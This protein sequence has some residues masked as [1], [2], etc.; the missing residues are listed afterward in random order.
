MSVEY[1]KNLVGKPIVKFDCPKCH[2][3]LSAMLAE[4]GTHDTCPECGQAFRVPGTLQL[5]K[6]QE[7][8]KL[9][10]EAKALAKQQR[11]R[12]SEKIEKRTEE[13]QESRADLAGKQEEPQQGLDERWLVEPE[14]GGGSE[15]GSSEVVFVPPVSQRPRHDPAS[16][17]GTV[18]YGNAARVIPPTRSQ[19]WWKDSV[20]FE[21]VSSSRYPALMAFRNVMLLLWWIMVMGCVI[22]FVC[23]P[24]VLLYGAY[25]IH[26]QSSKKYDQELARYDNQAIEKLLQK[27]KQGQGLD[28]SESSTLAEQFS[29]VDY[30]GFPL[31]GRVVAGNPVP[32]NVLEAVDQDWHQWTQARKDEVNADR[33]SGFLAFMA[34]VRYILVFWT[35]LILTL[36][37]YSIL[38]LVPPECIKLAIDIEHGVRVN[39]ETASA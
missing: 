1:T 36:I 8:R 11:Q 2:L 9:E 25:T 37:L 31:Q 14:Q 24:C 20:R 7:K 39:K 13:D 22:G 26:S 27:A 18:D 38:M 5:K 17:V 16:S 21:S 29:G 19:A 3:R 35:A 10:K 6:A 4:A 12:D 28:T 15:S 34:A 23:Y 33:P 32:A 30:R